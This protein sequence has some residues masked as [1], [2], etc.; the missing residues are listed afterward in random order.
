MKTKL[1]LF[2]IIQTTLNISVFSQNRNQDYICAFTNSNMEIDGFQNENVWN[3]IEPVWFIPNKEEELKE[4]SWFKVAWNTDYLLFYFWI[5]DEDIQA[6]MINHDDHL[7]LEEVMEIF[8]D[9]DDNPKT[10]YELEWNVLNTL[11]DLYVLNPNLNRTVIRQWWS[12][13]C[14]GILSAVNVQGTISNSTDVDK[15]WYLE[16]AIPFSEIQSAKNIPPIQGDIWRFDVTR[17]EGT[18]ESGTF[19]KSSWLPPSA[20]FPLS[21]GKLIFNQ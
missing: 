21:Y 20:H 1:F 15:G 10:Y 11:L 16:V 5:E 2:I 13:D 9:A 19:Q 8:I 3:T 4:K 14:E 7:W 6:E 12:W 17:R 18:E